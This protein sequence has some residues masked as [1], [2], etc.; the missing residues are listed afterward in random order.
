MGD[1]ADFFALI[2]AVKKFTDEIFLKHSTFMSKP[3]QPRPL[4]TKK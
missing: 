2:G 1:K 4:N 3:T